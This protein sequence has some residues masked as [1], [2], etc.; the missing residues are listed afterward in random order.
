ME[1]VPIKQAEKILSEAG[2]IGRKTLITLS[3]ADKINYDKSLVENPE[4]KWFPAREIILELIKNCKIQ[5]TSENNF[6]LVYG[7]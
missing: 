4:H 7:T 3:N 1:H 6:I 5:H 2:R